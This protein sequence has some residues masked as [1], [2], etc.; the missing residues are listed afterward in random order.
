VDD[1][2]YNAFERFSATDSIRLSGLTTLEQSLLKRRIKSRIARQ[3]WRTEGLF[4]V[5][6]EDDPMIKAALSRSV[7]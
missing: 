2:V 3:M 5:L 7:K 4:A 1:E 6:N